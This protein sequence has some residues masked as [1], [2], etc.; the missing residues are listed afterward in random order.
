MAGFQTDHVESAI[1]ETAKTFGITLKDKQFEAIYN[2]CLRKDVFISLPTGYGK[3]II[4][5]LLPVVLDRITG[6]AELYNYIG[7]SIASYSCCL[8]E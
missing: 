3:S 5:G 6:T 1:I 2:F 7:F 4:Y 8:H